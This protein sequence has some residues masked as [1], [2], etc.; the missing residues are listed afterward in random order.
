MRLS[1]SIAYSDRNRIDES[2]RLKILRPQRL[3]GFDPR[4]PHQDSGGGGRRFGARRRVV[5]GLRD[6]FPPPA[7]AR[8]PITVIEDGTAK[9]VAGKK[10]RRAAKRVPDQVRPP[11]PLQEQD[12]RALGRSPEVV[13]LRGL[14]GCGAS[15]CSLLQIVMLERTRHT[16]DLVRGK[17]DRARG[18]APARDDRADFADDASCLV[19]LH[20]EMRRDS[21][22]EIE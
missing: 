17:T 19:R 7:G 6:D 20:P 15:S 12:L 18:F 14:S 8:R 2:E 22:R 4:R 13:T 3:C 21:K 10:I 11:A 1:C 16:L 9:A 5:K